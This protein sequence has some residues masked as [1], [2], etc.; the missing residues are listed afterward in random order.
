MIKPILSGNT[1]NTYLVLLSNNQY[2]STKHKMCIRDSA[3]PTIM[4]IWLVKVPDYAVLFTQCKMCIRDR[5]N[6]DG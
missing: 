5:D 1:S 4:D 6:E 3:M 2:L